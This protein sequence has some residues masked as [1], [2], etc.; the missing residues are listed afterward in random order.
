[1]TNR[2][3]SIF[4]VKRVDD[5]KRII[6]GIATTPSVDRMGD[7]V[8]PTGAEYALPLPFL[9][10]HDSSKPIGHV[11]KAQ[12]T[13]GGISVEI[14][15]AKIDEPGPVKDRV[16]GAWQ[17][18]KHGLVK[19]LS[20]GFAAVEQ[21]YDKSTGGLHFLKWKWL[22]LSAVTIA[23]NQEATITTIKAAAIGR[24]SPAPGGTGPKKDKTMRK[25]FA[26]QVA[27]LEAEIGPK[28][29]RMK[30]IMEAAD[31]NDLDENDAEE[32]DSLADEVKGLETKLRRVK[33]MDENAMTARPVR[34][35]D[36]EAG[37][38]SRTTVA[39]EPKQ[40]QEKGIGFAR[41][42]MCM[43]AAKGDPFRAMEFAKHHYP[44]ETGIGKLLQVKANIPG[45]AT[46][47][48]TWAAP[49]VYAD[50]LVSEFVEYLRPQ[51][52]IGR[53][54]QGNVPGLRRVPF[55]V[56]MPT[57]T[58]G[59][60][61]YWV[62]EGAPKPLTKFDFSRITLGFT[63]VA[64]IAVLTN[65]LI[66]FSNPSAELVVRDALRDAL[67]ARLD[68]DFANPSITLQAGIR[69]A[70][71][72]NGASNSAATNGD[73]AAVVREDI[74]E[75]ISYFISNN[76]DVSSLVILMRSS[77]ALSLSLMR[78]TLGVKEFPGMTMAGGELEG[79][80]VLASQYIPTG[81][82]AFVS[83]TN[84]FLADDG[85]V[86]IQLSNEASLEM[87]S[88]SLTQSVNDGGSPEEA[89]GASLVSMFQTNSVAI[90]AERFINWQRRRST[91]VYYFTNTAW[92]DPSSP[93]T[94]I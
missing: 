93:F 17:D 65:E 2:A 41:L 86:D 38:R 51:T 29:L 75:A 59:G 80:P 84:I 21:A 25:T 3:Y 85:G 94:A 78:S 15:L 68:S 62:G 39:P 63:K 42:A 79:I 58:S 64:N 67:V 89:T 55:N 11:T 53:F 74:R 18:I 32:F 1:M 13:K 6:S 52:L 24:K 83:A 46:T 90:R 72:L 7:V 76:I 16:D 30:S 37:T 43:I 91:A 12:V 92:G 34:G 71:I 82:V 27:D 45:G 28:R 22:E 40:H 77:Q 10:Q 35:D 8:E 23:A 70:S 5:E 87:L 47:D 66:R 4:T 50:N 20:I 81:I 44:R 88:S 69:P 36:S 26:Q 73:S 48:P 49:L 9:L 19:G 14:Q 33:S 54:G 56:S 61:G 31:G 60:D 57:Q